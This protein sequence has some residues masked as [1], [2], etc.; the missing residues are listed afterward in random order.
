[1]IARW[2][3]VTKK[4]SVFY[5]EPNPLIVPFSAYTGIENY[6][7]QLLILFNIEYGRIEVHHPLTR[8]RVGS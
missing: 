6:K 1:M 2:D 8:S 3:A 5:A 7:E 4:A